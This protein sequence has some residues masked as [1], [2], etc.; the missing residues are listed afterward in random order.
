[1]FLNTAFQS[2]MGPVDTGSIWDSLGL[3][4]KGM[5]GVLLVMLLIFLV[6]VVLNKVFNRS[7]DDKKDD[8]D[9]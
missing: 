7:P 3:L 8:Q 4:L 6:I 1:M 5:G 2:L 9:K